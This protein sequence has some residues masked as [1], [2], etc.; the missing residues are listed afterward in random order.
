M[1]KKS[2]I[3]S[4]IIHTFWSL[5]TRQ[6]DMTDQAIL[7]ELKRRHPDAVAAESALLVDRHLLGHIAKSLDSIGFAPADAPAR[8]TDQSLFGALPGTQLPLFVGYIDSNGERRCK[9]PG[10]LTMG[11]FDSVIQLA[12][13]KV[14]RATKTL[15]DWLAKRAALQPY[16]EGD[17]ARTLAEAYAAMAQAQRSA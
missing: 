12:A 5:Y 3:S 11:E 15:E 13:D 4:A 1:G 9:Q 2:P 7:A 8:A 10:L 17:P 16:W 6:G 14:Q